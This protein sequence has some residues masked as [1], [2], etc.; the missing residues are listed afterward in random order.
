[1]TF[2]FTNL[3]S[4]LF[5]SFIFQ[6]SIAEEARA[7]KHPLTDM[8]G[9]AEDMRTSYFFPH[10]PDLKLPIGEVITALCHFSNDGSGYYNISGIMGSLNAPID[11][12]HHFQNYSYKPFGMVVKGGEEISLRYSFQ[13]HPELDPVDYQLA[14]TVFYDSE[15]ESFSNTFFNQT[16]ELYLPTSEYDM[17]TISAVL[18]SLLSTAFVVAV[19]VF[20]CFPEA[21]FSQQVAKRLKKM[22]P[23]VVEDS[24]V[25]EQLRNQQQAGPRKSK[26]NKG[27][28]HFSSEDDSYED[29][30]EDD[31]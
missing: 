10:Q 31:E 18:Y 22:F 14:I 20:A 19:T 9:S 1:M 3:I 2:N 23:Q 26:K 24:L 27:N 30:D 5:M 17:D 8:P 4:I 11:F 16:V 28:R 7:F 25:P 15:S 13:L 12:R 29:V 6:Q 21:K